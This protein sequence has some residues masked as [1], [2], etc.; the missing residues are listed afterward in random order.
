[1]P[2]NL[3]NILVKSA[4][5]GFA[6]GAEPVSVGLINSGPGVLTFATAPAAVV[7]VWKVL[8]MA[9]L[10]IGNSVM[11]PIVLSLVVGM[12]IY[13]TAPA[14]GDRAAK[15]R[16]FVF[17]FINSFAIAATALGI[18]VSVGGSGD[19]SKLSAAPVISTPS[20]SPSSTDK[21]TR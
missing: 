11:F 13:Y 20:V 15:F 5:K 2:T 19:Q 18:N 7:T 16:G 9:Y 6:D 12:A 14:T 10:N 8:G 17:A 1:M 3:F 21:A 4:S